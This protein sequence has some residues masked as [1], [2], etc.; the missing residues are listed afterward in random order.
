MPKRERGILGF[1]KPSTPILF[2]AQGET[3][4]SD[5]SDDDYGTSIKVKPKKKTRK[6]RTNRYSKTCKEISPD[7][8]ATDN[9]W[10]S[11]VPPEILFKIFKHVTDTEGALPFLCRVSAVCILWHRVASDEHLWCN[12]DLSYGWIKKQASWLLWLSEHRLQQVRILNLSGWKISDLKVESALKVIVENCKQLESIGLSRCKVPPTTLQL[13][14]SCD[15][16]K[17]I[18]LSHVEKYQNALKQLLEVKGKNLEDIRL[19]G[20]LCN[21]SKIIIYLMAYCPN[22]V[23]VD[24]SNPSYGWANI[25]IDKFQASCPRLKVFRAANTALTATGNHIE[26]QWCGFAELEEFTIPSYKI[27][28][29]GQFLFRFLRGSRKLR[30]LDIRDCVF[31][32][33]SL[34]FLSCLTIEYLYLSRC[35][36]TDTTLE[37]IIASWASS[38]IDMDISWNPVGEEGLHSCLLT[39]AQDATQLQILNLA[40]TTANPHGVRSVIGG[41]GKLQSLNL[42]SCRCMPRGVKRQFDGKKQ[43]KELRRSLNAQQDS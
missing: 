34:L 11:A 9:A 14:T 24:I 25:D 19:A 26:S 22:L 12:V 17:G 4:P 15:N 36:I 3:W 8:Q 38:L 43:L 42:T 39:L 30:L 10:Q 1:V 27:N 31:N 6:K 37:Q 28:D 7:R 35:S 16:L 40:G 33:E 5:D 13:L 18:D 21:L 41:C 29:N 32:L 23:L 2:S 20:C